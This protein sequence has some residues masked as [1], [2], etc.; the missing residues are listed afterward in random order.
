MKR[1]LL[2]VTSLILMLGLFF[3]CLNLPVETEQGIKVDGILDEWVNLNEDAI[4]DGYW[5]A[6]NDIIKVGVSFDASFVYFAGDFK[7]EGFN[8]LIFLVDF[9]SL[10]GATSTVGHPWTRNYVFDSGD[11]DLVIETWGDGFAMWKVTQDGTFTEITSEATLAYTGNTADGAERFVEIA[12][13]LSSLGIT[14]TDN[15]QINYVTSITGGFDGTSQWLGDFAPD[16]DATSTDGSFTP[17][18]TITQ[19]YQVP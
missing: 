16:Q 12:V 8:N 2:L 18:A 4:G 13:P 11:I 6:G 19:F 3:G 15:L 17:A 14:S 10:T 1:A 5:G 9:S 7:K